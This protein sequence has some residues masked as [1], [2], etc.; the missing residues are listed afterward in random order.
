[1]IREC[2]DSSFLIIISYL[3]CLYVKF[4]LIMQ[5]IYLASSGVIIRYDKKIDLKIC[6]ML[7]LECVN[8]VAKS[9]KIYSFRI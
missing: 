8:H 5:I 9:E 4:I 2:I 6:V 3:A 1:M 7:H